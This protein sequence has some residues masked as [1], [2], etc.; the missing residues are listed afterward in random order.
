MTILHADYPSHIPCSVATLY[1]RYQPTD[2]ALVALASPNHLHEAM[3]L[4]RKG[5]EIA[6]IDVSVERVIPPEPWDL[7]QR[8][9]RGHQGRKEAAARGALDGNGPWA[10]LGGWATAQKS[11]ILAGFPGTSTIPLVETFL[12]GFAVAESKEEKMIY[13][14]P[15]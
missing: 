7:S 3:L 5:L 2:R 13:K 4:F 15:L 12:E 10:G 11:V 8:R 9:S 1:K 6:G 14:V